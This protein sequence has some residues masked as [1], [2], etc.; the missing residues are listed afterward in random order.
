MTSEIRTGIDRAGW[1]FPRI[2]RDH[3]AVPIFRRL[4]CG[5]P[6]ERNVI[7]I[8]SIVA[9]MRIAMAVTSMNY[10]V[11]VAGFGVVGLGLSNI[12]PILIS[13]AGRTSA[14]SSRRRLR[15]FLR[16]CGLSGQ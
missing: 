16:L 14:P 6:G 9:I 15:R 10:L 8:S 2:L 12:V 13:A 4:R 3:G 7:V 11:V 5:A 1:A